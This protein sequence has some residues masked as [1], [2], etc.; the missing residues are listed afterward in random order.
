MAIPGSDVMSVQHRPCKS[1]LRK[2][3]SFLWERCMFDPE[4]T[5]RLKQCH[6]V[7]STLLYVLDMKQ[8]AKVDLMQGS[9]FVAPC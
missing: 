5:A 7:F 3:T 6:K 1:T 8:P 4:V 2:A 9:G